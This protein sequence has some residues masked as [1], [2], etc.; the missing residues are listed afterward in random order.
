MLVFD[1]H[2]L[3]KFFKMKCALRDP[4]VGFARLEFNDHVTGGRKLWGEFL[5]RDGKCLSPRKTAEHFYQLV[6]KAVAA[7]RAA[8]RRRISDLILNGA[9]VTLTIDRK[10]D[11]DLVLSVEI[12]GWPSCANAWGVFASNKTWPTKT[13][14]E[15]I[16]IKEKRVHLVAKP[17]PGEKRTRDDSQVYWRISFSE[18]EKILLRPASSG[19]E[20]KYYRIAKAIFEACKEDLKPLSSYHLKTLFLH[21]RR[22]SPQARS[23]DSNLGESVVKFFARL[24]DRLKGGHLPHFFVGPRVSLFSEMS[25]R[26]RTNLACQLEYFLNKLVENPGKFLSSLTI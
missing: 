19:C 17:C 8:Q 5:T 3:A 22:A 14:V 15:Q 1:A 10:I 13:E 4:C 9:A 26:T 11:L 2:L 18:A 16:K 24:I 23:D 21:L 20:K 6:C 7:M 12:S 25:G